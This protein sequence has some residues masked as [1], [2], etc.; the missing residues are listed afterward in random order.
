M[1]RRGDAATRPRT[2]RPQNQHVP[3]AAEAAADG[4]EAQE[5]TSFLE[6]LRTFYAFVGLPGVINIVIVSPV[7]LAVFLV[8]LLW[9]LSMKMGNIN[10]TW[11]KV[12]MEFF[13]IWSGAALKLLMVSFES[14]FHA[15]YEF[16]GEELLK[17]L[18]VIIPL[19]IVFFHGSSVFRAESGLIATLVAHDLVYFV[20]VDIV[21]R[22]FD[23]FDCT[24][25]IAF[26][27]LEIIFC[28]RRVG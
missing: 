13:T 1:D 10:P 12:Y 6:D 5:E 19:R 16:L 28:S 25:T 17:E 2:R 3:A 22:V 7:L 24:R 20:V 18:F 4:N 26:L 27:L 8:V 23:G 9:D 11:Y 21:A 15:V 14:V